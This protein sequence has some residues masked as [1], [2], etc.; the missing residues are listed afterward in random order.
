MLLLQSLQSFAYFV[1]TLGGSVGKAKLMEDFLPSQ[2]NLAF[3]S[4]LFHVLTTL[5]VYILYLHLC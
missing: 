2:M 5:R 1:L 3:P 4:F